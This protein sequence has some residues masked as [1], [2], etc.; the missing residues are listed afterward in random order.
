MQHDNFPEAL[1][2]NRQRAANI[3]RRLDAGAGTLAACKA[4]GISLSTFFTWENESPEFK[5][6]LVAQQ[7]ARKMAFSSRLIQ[8]CKDVHKAAEHRE[9]AA[10]KLKALE[11]EA[12]IIR[13]HL[14][15]APAISCAD[16]ATLTAE[17]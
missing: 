11:I 6:E 2:Y 17:E 13:W 7:V 5:K 1:P 14:E 16:Y 3:L 15:H 10:N 9:N 4:E 12:D 8:I